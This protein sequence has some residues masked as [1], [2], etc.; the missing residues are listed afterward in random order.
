MHTLARVAALQLDELARTID[1]ADRE[2]EGRLH[3]HCQ[4][5][6]SWCRACPVYNSRLASCHSPDQGVG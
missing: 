5:V 6:C 3:P 1:K 2:R 4:G